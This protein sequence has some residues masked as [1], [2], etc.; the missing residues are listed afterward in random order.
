M[1]YDSGV[2]YGGFG[3]VLEPVSESPWTLV[4]LVFLAPAVL[5]VLAAPLLIVYFVFGPLV[6]AALAVAVV[7]LVVV[8]LRRRTWA[9]VASTDA[10]RPSRAWKVR[11]WP[12]SREAVDH[13]AEAVRRGELGA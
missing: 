12:A 13:I 9:V 10:D 6:L 2:E 11:G 4:H 7:V 3:G 1:P 5:L 8:W